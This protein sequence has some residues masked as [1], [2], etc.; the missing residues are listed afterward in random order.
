MSLDRQT[1]R[2][3]SL[4]ALER[5]K[6]DMLELAKILYTIQSP[7]NDDLTVD[8][9]HDHIMKVLDKR[10]VQY[11]ILTG[12][13]LDELAEDDKLPQPLQEAIETDEGLF[14]IDEIL[15]LSIVQCYGTIAFTNFGYLDKTKPS[16]IGEYNNKVNGVHCFLDDLLSAII[17]AAASRMAH[18][19]G[20]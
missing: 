1:L 3:A 17:A 2:I 18:G 4:E 10:E 19:N 9:C 7:Y 12:I 6:V 5:R 15:A 20:K 16:I 14:G 13:A 11:A 8:E